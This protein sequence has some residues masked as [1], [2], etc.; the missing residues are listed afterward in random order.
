MTAI[1]TISLLAI[2]AGMHSITPGMVKRVCVLRAMRIMRMIATIAAVRTITLA[3][4][5]TRINL[6]V[7]SIGTQAR[8]E[9]IR[10]I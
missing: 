6:A 9:H 7:T 10:T 1:A 8:M 3:F 4:I 5:V 2:H